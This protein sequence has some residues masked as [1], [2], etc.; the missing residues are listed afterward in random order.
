M[1]FNARKK[2]IGAY[3]STKILS[4]TMACPQCQNVLVVKTDP[5]STEYLCA[6]G[7]RRK[8][9]EFDAKDAETLEF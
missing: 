7:C 6:E 1:R 8:V 3:L 9:E 4:F 5:K 2:Q